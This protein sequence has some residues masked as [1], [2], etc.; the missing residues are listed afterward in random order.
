MS[1]ELRCRA[2]EREEMSRQLQE[3]LRK[4]EVE[5]M[6]REVRW[7]DVRACMRVLGE[8]LTAAMGEG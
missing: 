3:A 4:A 5:A 2:S 8:Q 7:G 6:A 1:D